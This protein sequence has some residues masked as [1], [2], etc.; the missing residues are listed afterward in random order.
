ML[1]ARRLVARL[2]FLMVAIMAAPVVMS[3]S[4][5]AA[6]ALVL[7]DHRPADAFGKLG[8]AYAIMLRNLLGHFNVT[9]DLVP[10]QNYTAGSIETHDATFYLG[11]FYDNQVPSAFLSDVA[12]TQKTVVWFKHNIWQLAWNSAYNFSARYGIAFDGLRGLNAAPSS[13]N[14]APGFFDTILYGGKQMVKYYQYDAATNKVFA[15]PEIGQARVANA[16]LAQVVAQVKNGKT[17]EQIPYV[18]RAGNFWYVADLPLSYIGPRDRYLALCDLLHDMLG[19]QDA[20][21]HRAMVRL[22]DVGAKVS[23]TA[24][25]QLSDD[26]FTRQIPF[27]IA[28]IPFYR[29]PLGAYNGGAPEEVHANAG[30]AAALRNSLNYARTRGASIVMHGYT[31]QYAAQKNPWTGV[32]GDDFEMWNIVANTPT[33][34]DTQA[35]A[36]RRLDAGIAELTSIGYTAFAWETPHYHASP[37]MS[38][39]VP[40]RFPTAYQRAVYYTDDAGSLA[41]GEYAVGQF[42]PYIIERDYYGQRILPENLGN[43]EYDISAIDPSSNVVYTAQDILTN[44]D[45]ARVVRDGF[46]SFFF[47]PFW[48]EAGLPVTTGRADFRQV[49]DGIKAMGYTRVGGVSLR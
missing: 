23:Q 43:I 33:S 16:A 26:L 46:A 21:T 19:R 35:E 31:H 32:S 36:L 47:H 12:V 2:V 3:S 6:G 44:A 7:Y 10:V 41:N 38:R 14:P 20:V 42:F 8:K 5:H 17:G 9:V 28:V 45:Y 40:L 34:P 37:A 27:S 39:A 22:E 24:M 1:G 29:D 18:T 13:A 49:I 11:A 15:D 30:G 48:L 25:Q 4:A